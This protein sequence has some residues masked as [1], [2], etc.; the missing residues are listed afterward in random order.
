MPFCMPLWGLPGLFQPI[1]AQVKL[2]DKGEMGSEQPDDSLGP[3]SLSFPALPGGTGCPGHSFLSQ[4][5]RGF[6]S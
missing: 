5:V 6:P 3:E 1:K 4:G 2:P